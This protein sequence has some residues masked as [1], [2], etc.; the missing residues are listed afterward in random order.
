MYEFDA[1][2]VEIIQRTP[3]VKSFRFEVPENITF[4]PGQYLTLTIDEYGKQRTKPFSISSSSYEEGYIEFTKRLTDSNFSKVLDS[5]KTGDH[6]SLKFPFGNFTFDGEYPKIALLS[7]GI[8][9]TPFRSIC[10]NAAEKKLKSDI[11]LMYGNRTPDEIVFRH[12]FDL[13]AKGNKYFN[14]RYYITGGV[15]EGAG[16]MFRLGYIDKKSIEIEIPD[17]NERVFYVCGPP[18]MVKSLLQILKNE[19]EINDDKI[20]FENFT[21]Y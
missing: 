16:D 2:I 10:G 14:V 8:G 11:I 9:V 4:I 13:M 20:M 19:L 1:K 18:G 12:D 7:G 6:G 15:N 21:G 3:T 5:M 17:Y